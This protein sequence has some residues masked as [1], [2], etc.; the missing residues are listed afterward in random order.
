[1]SLVVFVQTY[2]VIPKL[3]RALVM[4]RDI[5]PNSGQVEPEHLETH[6]QNQDIFG[7]ITERHI[8][9]FR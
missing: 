8:L 5:H 3:H 1:M 9:R 4:F 7:V 2:G 6:P